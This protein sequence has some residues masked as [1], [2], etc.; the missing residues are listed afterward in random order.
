MATFSQR[1]GLEPLNKV[2][3]VESIDDELRNRL[4][5]I[6]YMWFFE[7]VEYER[8]HY[9]ELRRSNL[10]TQFFAYHARF[11]KLPVDGLPEGYEEAL[12]FI[13]AFFFKCRWNHALDF[14]E[15]T[16]DFQ[17]D[18][19]IAE[20]FRTACNSIFDQ[21]NAGYRFVGDKIAE[22]TA[23]EEIQSVEDA[24]EHAAILPGVRTHLRTALS[25][26]TSR[27]KPDYRNSIKESISAIES[28]VR[29]IAGNDA[30]LSD[31]L[32][33]LEQK[34]TLHGALKKAFDSLY[35][36]TNDAGGLRHA[37]L[38]EKH[39]SKADA[40]FMLIA[41]SAFTNYI[42]GKLGEA[43]IDARKFSGK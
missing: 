43:G 33:V 37:M 39:H 21:E 6:L 15:F 4:W 7:D 5:N 42:L 35:G 2:M 3:Q 30:N 28:L 10:K 22:I 38:E 18:A 9:G 40:Q 41:C 26:L 24:L 25:H 17:S 16:G 34:E 27:E 8:H 13:R 31:A 29:A 11:F 12:A 20:K 1:K 32:K 14:L 19:S 36:Y 23:P